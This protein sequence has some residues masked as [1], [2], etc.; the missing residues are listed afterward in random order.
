MTIERLGRRP[1]DGLQTELIV[2]A[3]V[4]LALS[5][6]VPQGPIVWVVAVLACAGVVAAGPALSAA[7]AMA[8]SSTAAGRARTRAS[9]AGSAAATAATAAAVNA[10][11]TAATAAAG[12]STASSTA[13]GRAKARASAAGS[14]TATAAGNAAATA[15]A[16]AATAAR[17]LDAGDDDAAPDPAPSR[18]A[19]ARPI[20]VGRL[21]WRNR[22]DPRAPDVHRLEAPIRL[23]PA[24]ESALVPGMLVASAVLAGQLLPIGYAIVPALA[25]AAFVLDRSLSAERRWVED[26]PSSDDRL[27][28][29]TLAL[30]AAFVGFSGIAAFVHGG[31]VG[32]GSGGGVGAGSGG[33][34]AGGSA[35][36]AGADAIGETALLVLAG[37]DGVIAGIL[38]YRLTRLGPIAPREA[39]LS[40]VTYAAVI[41]IGAGLLRAMAVPQLL[42]PAL[43]TLLVYLWDAFHAT[44]PSIRRDPRWL[45]QVGLLVALSVLVVGWNLALRS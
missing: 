15:A 30:V 4:V 22:F 14:A 45:W 43:L 40:A 19:G 39:F 1:R 21:D 17:R 18:P 41:A 26:G 28:I 35:A 16:T 11:A 2:S 23:V 31:L 12:N 5:R 34:A 20:A 38:G 42:G 6:L 36:G 24:V 44:T 9:A 10:A 29:L 33:S 8:A 3:M 13:A 7:A 27:A 25:A 32:F 37:A